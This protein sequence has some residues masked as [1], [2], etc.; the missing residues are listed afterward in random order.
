MARERSIA[1]IED[2]LA[3]DRLVLLTAQREGDTEEPEPDDLYKV[4]TVAMVMRILRMGD[5]RVKVLV[6][7]L[8]KARIDAFLE[9]ERARWV[10]CTALPTDE[11]AS[12]S[13]EAEALIRNV[14]VRVEELLPL[15]NLPPEVLSVTANV[16]EAGRLADLVA[17]HLRLRPAEAQELLETVDP[18][19]RLRR[20]D[21]LLRRELD[22]TTVQA[23]IQSQARDEM[24]RGQRDAFL[25]E[26]LRAI[27]AELGE[28]D[29][30]GEEVDDYRQKLEEAGLPEEP[31]VEAMKPGATA[32][33]HAPGG[34]RGPRRA[35]LSR[36]DGGAAL[37]GRVAGSSGSRARQDRS[38]TRTT[39]TCTAIKDR[40]LEYLAVRKL[41]GDSRGPILCFVGPPGVGKTSLGPV[42]RPKRWDVSSSVSRWAVCAMRRRFA[43]IGAPTW[44]RCRG[45][46]SR[47]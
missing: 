3:G 24:D 32:R 12:W 7:G 37:E 20:V 1:A 26:Q 45:A 29:P 44:A 25:R 4:G 5:G 31:M 28:T 35:Q 40:I 15:K 27:Q 8:A 41:R 34:P 43:D 36:L 33:T 17:S 23:E 6:Q 16:H 47:R 38:S 18:L 39:R 10:R 9:H 30:R 42:D 11:E 19:V 22:V 2:A 21:S 13:V 46:S 14:R